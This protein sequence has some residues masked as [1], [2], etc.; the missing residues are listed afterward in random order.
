[1]DMG[2]KPRHVLP[3]SQVAGGD[4]L[5]KLWSFPRQIPGLPERVA[6]EVLHLPRA[7][8]LPREADQG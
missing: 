2:I 8:N 5:R 1:M 6:R 3:T 7:R 4:V